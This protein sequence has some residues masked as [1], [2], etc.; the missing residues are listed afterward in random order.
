MQYYFEEIK[1]VIPVVMFA[2]I[3]IDEPSSTHW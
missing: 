3:H 1:V 2:V